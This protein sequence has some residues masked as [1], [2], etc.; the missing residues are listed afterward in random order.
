MKQLYGEW[1]TKFED[2][3]RAYFMCYIQT[4]NGVETSTVSVK[5]NTNSADSIEELIANLPLYASTDTKTLSHHVRLDSLRGLGTDYPD[6]GIVAYVGDNNMDK[7]FARIKMI[8]G[9]HKF[10]SHPQVNLMVKRYR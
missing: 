4:R 5:A 9:S 2:E 7:P 10:V 3:Q 6:Y 8:N 1:T